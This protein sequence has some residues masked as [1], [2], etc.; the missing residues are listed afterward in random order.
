MFEDK[1]KDME[2]EFHTMIL[3]LIDIGFDVNN[4]DDEGETP[5]HWA[6]FAGAIWTTKFLL[7][8]GAN[9]MIH[10]YNRELPI[11]VARVK[12]TEFLDRDDNK[13]K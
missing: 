11:D 13:G 1:D 4:Q 9:P 6:A 7:R 12:P 8:N 3:A 10:N 2:E 5:L